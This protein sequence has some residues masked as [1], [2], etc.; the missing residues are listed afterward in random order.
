MDVEVESQFLNRGSNIKTTKTTAISKS[1]KD[2]VV[3]VSGR[4]YMD[5]EVESQF[6]SRESHRRK[7]N[8]KKITSPS[9]KTTTSSKSTT[10][11]VVKLLKKKENLLKKKENL[12]NKKEN[13]LKKKENF[14]TNLMV[15]KYSANPSSFTVVSGSRSE[16]K[17]VEL[18]P[19]LLNR[20]IKDS[21][22][23]LKNMINTSV[24][25][26]SSLVTSTTLF[27]STLSRDYMDVKG[28]TN[29]L[30]KDRNKKEGSKIKK[31]SDKVK[32]VQYGSYELEEYQV[33]PMS[34]EEK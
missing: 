2:K 10:D 32:I 6:L 20:E 9:T 22:E 12:L 5:V 24:G 16:D 13:L 33:A 8:L 14:K 18:K 31:S 30:L 25:T 21:K 11:K 1:K 23:N 34:G 17:D 27:F 3:T 28:E 15:S 19:Q 29:T 7:E 26:T 4:D